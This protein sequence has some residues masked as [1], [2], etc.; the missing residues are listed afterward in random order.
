[1]KFLIYCQSVTNIYS[2][3]IY[4]HGCQYY[5]LNDCEAIKQVNVDWFC[6][7]QTGYSPISR[8]ETEKTERLLHAS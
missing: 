2:S 7:V 4:C 1:M 6:V 8:G 5:T 3:I